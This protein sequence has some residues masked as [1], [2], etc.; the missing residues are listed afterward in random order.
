MS[1]YQ[2][3]D[4]AGN[5]NPEYTWRSTL[6]MLA[7]VLADQETTQ[8]EKERAADILR[9][10]VDR[11]KNS[12]HPETVD[13]LLELNGVSLLWSR[14]D[15]YQLREVADKEGTITRE[16]TQ[17]KDFPAYVMKIAPVVANPEEAKR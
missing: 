9:W 6:E 12:P 16:M 13:F 2:Q 14:P 3:F 7:A 15:Y 8:D 11:K 1:K 17:V 10:A 5:Y 4:A